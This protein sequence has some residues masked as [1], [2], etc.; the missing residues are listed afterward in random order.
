MRRFGNK[1]MK[2]EKIKVLMLRHNKVDPDPRVEKEVN[3]LLENKN[4]NIEVLAWDRTENYK[5]RK[6]TLSLDN[7][8][9]VIHR[10]GIVAGWGVGM[11]K[12][13]IAFVKYVFRTFGWLM[14]HH[15]EYDIV[16]ACD[17][18]TVIPA[19]FP[20]CLYRKKI[21]YDI[22]DYFSDTAHG[23]ESVLKIARWFETRVI[24]HASATI[25][26][27]EQREEQIKPA[28][29]KKLAIIH[30]APAKHQIETHSP[31]I[32]QSDSDKPKLVYVG[33]LVEDR[34][35]RE[36]V[37]LAK[38]HQDVEFHIGGM[39]V[40]ETL[41]QETEESLSNFYFYGKMKYSDV[42]ALE[43]ACDIMIAFY[44]QKVRNHRYAAPNKFYEALGL[45]KPLIMLHKTGVDDVIDKYELGST[46][47]Q[48]IASMSNGINILLNKKNEWKEIERKSIKLFNEKYCWEIMGRRLNDLYNEIIC[49]DIK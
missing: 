34:C 16:H 20:I 8:N 42:L 31:S 36:I 33:N 49:E 6:D 11:K 28:I 7:G 5:Y 41:M 19:L 39:G 17:L 32:C 27:S 13:A 14:K 40:L 10:I 30:N 38:I 15:K 25:I 45:G 9:V 24:N 43:K 4:L 47:D 48:N 12:N 35:M 1:T 3:S 2:K 26:C 46:V 44:D 23:S 21:V 22:Y 37:E 18:Q 29:P